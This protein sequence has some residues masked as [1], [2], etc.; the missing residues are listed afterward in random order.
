MACLRAAL[1]PC[2]CSPMRVL[3]IGANGFLGSHIVA[4]LIVA[5]HSV[6]ACARRPQAWRDRWPEHDA[7][8]CDFMRDTQPEAWLPRLAGIDAVVNAAG[9]FAERGGLTHRKVHL[10]GP[11]ALF[12]ACRRAGVRRIVHV[13]ALGADEAA[14]TGYARSKRAAE[15]ALAAMDELDWVIL[16]PSLV[17]GAAASGGMALLRALAALPVAIPLAGDGQQRLAPLHLDDF[18][19][20]VL[21]FLEP[22]APARL[23]LDAV[24]SEAQTLRD[25]LRGLRAWLGFAP[26]RMI[27]LPAGLM[28][29]VCALGDL[30]RWP[31]VNGTAYR[32]LRYGNVADARPLAE[33]AGFMPRGFS[34]GLASQPATAQDRAQARLYPVRPLLRWSLALVWLLSGVVS[35]LPG[36]FAF[37]A[38][39]LAPFGLPAAASSTVVILG[40]AAD[41]AIGMALLL[42]WRVRL[43]AWVSLAVMLGYTIIATIVVPQQWLDP[44]GSLLKNLAVLGAT[45]AMLAAEDE[46]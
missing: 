17:Y 19:R 35:L 30:M 16:R 45:L 26:A 27:A 18:T 38:A 42:R 4:A 34:A 8:A 15:D 36:G 20:A 23:R 41:L 40:A 10:E 13:S 21:R 14:G 2:L 5:G 44:L 11:L 29:L 39:A 46:S 1:A 33:A 3:V 32:M 25:I 31:T 12:E 9:I 43:A 6:V 22:G 37:G 7:V 28:R 24:G